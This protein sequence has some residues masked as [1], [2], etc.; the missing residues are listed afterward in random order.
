MSKNQSKYLIFAKEVALRN[1]VKTVPKFVKTSVRDYLCITLVLHIFIVK[2]RCILKLLLPLQK[3]SFYF[4]TKQAYTH[5]ANVNLFL[6]KKLNCSINLKFLSSSDIIAIFFGTQS[7][8]TFSL[9]FIQSQGNLR[10][11][12]YAKAFLLKLFGI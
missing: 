4:A 9:T 12:V 7:M 2:F 5:F 6:K 8:E 1:I 10:N 11:S 3:N